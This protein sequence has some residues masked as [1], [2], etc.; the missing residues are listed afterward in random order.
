MTETH[1]LGGFR[2]GQNEHVGLADLGTARSMPLNGSWR[3]GA[4][5]VPEFSLT[6][7]RVR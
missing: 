6:I 5:A 3:L 4:M 2:L 7:T 1:V